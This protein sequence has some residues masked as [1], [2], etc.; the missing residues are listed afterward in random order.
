MLIGTEKNRYVYGNLYCHVLKW[1]S[2]SKLNSLR[3]LEL[4]GK[5][6]I[7]DLFQ[8]GSVTFKGKEI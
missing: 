2:F 3:L 4:A 1:S 5:Q 6:G 7:Y 8:K